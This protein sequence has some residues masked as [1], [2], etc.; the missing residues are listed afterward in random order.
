MET[1]AQ[2][3]QAALDVQNASNLSG[4][5]HAFSRALSLLVKENVPS[6]RTHPI[7]VLFAVQV[8]YLAGTSYLCEEK[9]NYDAAYKECERLAK[10]NDS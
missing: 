10:G 6:V 3:A 4:V 5:V 9:A 7:S 1:I 8:G 2:A